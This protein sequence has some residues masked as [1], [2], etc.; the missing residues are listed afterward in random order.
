MSID[1]ETWRQRERLSYPQLGRMLKCSTSQAR[2]YCT[3]A[4]NVA[5]DLVDLLMDLTGGQF[6]LFEQHKRRQAWLKANRPGRGR[7]AV[8]DLQA[9]V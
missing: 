6:C 8:V 5:D 1:L 7:P 2:R 9:E 4:N 3:G